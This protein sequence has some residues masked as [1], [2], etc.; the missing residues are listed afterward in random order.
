MKKKEKVI[1][2]QCY[3]I[4]SKNCED[5][6]TD[7]IYLDF[8]TNL[9]VFKKKYLLSVF[10]NNE[11]FNILMI[12]MALYQALLQNAIS[13]EISEK[14]MLNIL[15]VGCNIYSPQNKRFNKNFYFDVLQKNN[16]IVL[17]PILNS[18]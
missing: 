4:L 11:N 12:L 3:T 16:C 18:Q 15:T 7:D 14:V 17:A 1:F 8:L 6:Q 2:N 10:N 5:S 13:W 9:D